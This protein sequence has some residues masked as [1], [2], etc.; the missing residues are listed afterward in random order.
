MFRIII[1]LNPGPLCRRGM[2]RGRSEQQRVETME[3]RYEKRRKR[4]LGGRKNKL[5]LIPTWNL[6]SLSLRQ[7]NSNS[8][9]SVLT[10]MKE[11][12]WEVLLPI[13][14]I[15][16]R[17]HHIG[18]IRR[19]WDS[20][21]PL[22]ANGH[23]PLR[24]WEDMD[25]KREHMEQK[26]SSYCGRN[27][28]DCS[29][30][31]SVERWRSSCR[32]VQTGNKIPNGDVPEKDNPSKRG[33]PQ[34]ASGREKQRDGV[35]GKFRPR[36]ATNEAGEGLLQLCWANNIALVNS[37]MKQRKRGLNQPDAAGAK[38]L[39]EKRNRAAER[40]RTRVGK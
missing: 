8:L 36:T 27:E 7:N 32:V 26:N 40:R 29:I 35:S 1:H 20:G 24:T 38:K 19:K 22:E 28:S 34:L 30:P 31:T 16:E 14:I 12:W 6:Q 5:K 15:R 13:E 9:T 17:W 10:Y 11:K 2:R 33:R 25:Q 4:R 18:G 37:F 23:H 21:G 3:R 39:D